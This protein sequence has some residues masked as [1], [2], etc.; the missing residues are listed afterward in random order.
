MY[1][2]FKMFSKNK[3]DSKDVN[4]DNSIV[5]ERFCYG[6]YGT[7]GRLSYD[8]FSCF[9]VERP[10][11][12]NTP[13]ISCIPDGK[14]TC[15]WYNSPKFGG[16]LAITGGT[17]SLFPSP[18]YDRNSILFHVG[19]WPRNF[20]GCIG[21]GKDFTCIRGDL[22]VTSSEDTINEFLDLFTQIDKIPLLI[23][24]STGTNNETT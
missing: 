2:L 16:T 23:V 12:D 13:Y 11:K 21:L 15:E 24:N 19:N 9:T 6:P 18:R 4:S 1:N 8:N 3:K 10:W 7:F 22:G 14:Y 5:I 17:V 20:E